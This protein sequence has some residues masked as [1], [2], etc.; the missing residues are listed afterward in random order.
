MLTPEDR[1]L[2]LVEDD[3]DPRGPDENADLPDELLPVYDESGRLV[4]NPVW[5]LTLSPNVCQARACWDYSLDRPRHK[6][7]VGAARLARNQDVNAPLTHREICKYLRPGWETLAYSL[8]LGLAC[9]YP[10]ASWSRH[11][12]NAIWS[13]GTYLLRARPLEVRPLRIVLAEEAH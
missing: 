4:A 12:S 5:P 1:G 9:A 10:A 13:A 6:F 11:G 2:E 8:T 7:L 3:V